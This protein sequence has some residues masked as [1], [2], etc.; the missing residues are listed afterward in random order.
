MQYSKFSKK[1]HPLGN[2]SMEG[3]SR[4]HMFFKIDV[5]RKLHSKTPVLESLFNKVFHKLY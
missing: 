3:S 5:I 4:S 2:K 1:M